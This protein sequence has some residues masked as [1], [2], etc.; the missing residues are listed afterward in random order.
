MSQL[1]SSSSNSCPRMQHNQWR[2]P[3][4]GAKPANQSAPARKRPTSPARV[5]FQRSASASK[6]NLARTSTRISWSTTAIVQTT[7]VLSRPCRAPTPETLWS[8]NW[9]LKSF[10]I[11]L[12]ALFLL[13]FH[14]HQDCESSELGF[15]I[16][17][18][19][20]KSFYVHPPFTAACSLPIT[21]TL[22]LILPHVQIPTPRRYEQSSRILRHFTS[23]I[24]RNK[25]ASRPFE[26]F[27]I[28]FSE[29]N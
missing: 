7:L 9:V 21:L 16:A 12:S 22:S 1:T 3:T 8:R 13:F 11:F 23:T 27:N 28:D 17:F 14:N 6:T 2:A 26:Y 4:A 5:I 18:Y 19:Q 29:I 25:E 15:R 20:H 24:S 10:L